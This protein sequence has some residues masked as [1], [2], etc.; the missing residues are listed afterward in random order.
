MLNALRRVASYS[1]AD[2]A[3][4]RNAT[5]AP[6]PSSEEGECFA[7]PRRRRRMLELRKCSQG[8]A[9][10]PSFPLLRLQPLFSWHQCSC[11]AAQS[12]RAFFDDN[13]TRS[14]RSNEKTWCNGKEICIGA[15]RYLHRWY[16]DSNGNPGALQLNFDAIAIRIRVSVTV[17]LNFD[18][19]WE[20]WDDW[21]YP[22]GGT[23]AR[24]VARSSER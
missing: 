7:L 15:V 23:V 14:S 17:S 16:R 9:A 20:Q 19:R 1:P 13:L 24:I 6:R 10:L 12:S 2:L 21:G 22:N 8:D 3:C 18:D 11:T 5:A 4:L